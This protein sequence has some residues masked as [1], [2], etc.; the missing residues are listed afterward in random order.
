MEILTPPACVSGG[1]ASH[2]QVSLVSSSLNMNGGKRKG[3]ILYWNCGHCSHFRVDRLQHQT[4]LVLKLVLLQ[5]LCRLVWTEVPAIYLGS[6]LATTINS[7]GNTE[8]QKQEEKG[9]E[10]E[11]EEEEEEEEYKWT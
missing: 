6:S 9:E 8:P 10:E 11:K 5:D 7:E 2:S 4:Q 1:G 3:K